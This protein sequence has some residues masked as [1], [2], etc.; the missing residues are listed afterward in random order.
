MNGKSISIGNILWRVLRQPIAEGLTIEQA[1]EFALEYLRLINAP[2]I[3]NDVVTNP[4]LELVEY[5]TILPDNL[6]N[7]KGVQYFR[8]S[9]SEGISMRYATDI[10][11]VDLKSEKNYNHKENVYESYDPYINDCSEYTYITQNCN[12][13]T[14]QRKGFVRIS[15]K[16]IATD[17]N[18]YPLIPDNESIKMGLEYYILHRF[19]EPLWVMGKIQ[20]KVFS[21]I[22]QKRHW[23]LGQAASSSIISSPDHLESIMNGL[24]R[25]IINTSAFENGYKNFGVKERIIKYH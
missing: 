20:D 16:A 25:L 11:H 13:I 8:D 23:Y 9:C 10:Y 4:P 3:F 2:L 24:N 14:S 19:M 7:I 22:E 12:I 6:L 18:N 21:Y 17:E 5:K 1:S 15:Y